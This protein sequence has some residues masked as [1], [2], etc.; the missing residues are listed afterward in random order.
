MSLSVTVAD[1]LYVNSELRITVTLKSGFFT[2][3]PLFGAKMAKDVLDW[4]AC[5]RT[6]KIRSIHW[7]HCKPLENRQDRGKPER[8]LI[9]PLAAIHNKPLLKLNRLCVWLLIFIGRY[10]LRQL[11]G[12]SRDY[13]CDPTT[14]RLRSNYDVSRTPVSTGRDSMQQKM[15]MSV[16]HRSRV[17]VESQLWYRLW[18]SKCLISAHLY[19]ILIGVA[20]ASAVQYRIRRRRLLAC[21]RA[22]PAVIIGQ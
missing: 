1:K 14:I 2:N 6:V 15:N 7:C 20:R 3:F 17:V 4:S 12:L 8:P 22:S 16:F 13:N 18:L 21:R 5:C 10:T 19:C 11:L 9:Q